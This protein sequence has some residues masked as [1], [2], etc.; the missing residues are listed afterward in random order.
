MYGNKLKKLRINKG[1]SQEKLAAVFHVLKSSISM[2]ENNV[3]MPSLELALEIATYFGVGVDY[4]LGYIPTNND[5]FQMV[6][7]LRKLFIKE[8]VIG[9]ND[10]LSRD[11]LKKFMSFIKTNKKFILPD[12]PFDK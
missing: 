2:Y 11:M 1:M 6:E 10:D 4:M 12:E 5:E 8:G 3:R 7:S 9:E